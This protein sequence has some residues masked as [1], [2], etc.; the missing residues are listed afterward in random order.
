MLE[1]YLNQTALWEYIENTNE[2][3]EKI[4]NNKTIKCRKE[5]KIK[6][7]RDKDGI[8]VVSNST[9][10]CKEPVKVEHKIDG[11][12]VITVAT[13]TDLLGEVEGYEV[14]LI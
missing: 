2:Y 11:R 9:V 10:Y 7:V 1:D 3:N 4:C 5:D 12:V 14:Y 6:L 8:Q 13:I